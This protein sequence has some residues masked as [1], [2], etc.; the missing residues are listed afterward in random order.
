MTG[1]PVIACSAA[2]RRIGTACTGR[3]RTYADAYFFTLSGL[4]GSAPFEHMKSA[5]A[6]APSGGAASQHQLKRPV[7]AWGGPRH[8][9][10]PIWNT[11]EERMFD[12]R[13]LYVGGAVMAVAEVITLVIMVATR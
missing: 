7:T 8:I 5:A 2:T 3:R 12:V 4:Q 11:T 13:Q 9:R 10:C 1:D 6:A